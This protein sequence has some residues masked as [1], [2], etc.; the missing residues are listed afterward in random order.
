M[1]SKDQAQALVTSR[2]ENDTVILEERTIEKDWGWV[3]FHQSRR[4]LETK[5]PRYQRFG[6]YAFLVNR[7]DGSVHC[8]DSWFPIESYIQRYEHQL[9]G[10]APSFDADLSLWLE[11]VRFDTTRYVYK[12]ETMDR[13]PEDRCRLWH[14]PAGDTI[15]LIF[16][17][18]PPM[19][20]AFASN[21]DIEEFYRNLFLGGRVLACD[22]I[23]LDGIGCVRLSWSSHTRRARATSGGSQFLSLTSVWSSGLAVKSMTRAI[24]ER[25]CGP[26]PSASFQATGPPTMSHGRRSCPAMPYPDFNM[27]WLASICH[28][29]LM[30]RL[31]IKNVLSCRAMRPNP[32]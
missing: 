18:M 2:L 11:Q 22:V 16:T 15:K 24:S 29:E 26:L 12:G 28:S 14:T 8:A 19:L 27:S 5:D 31:R 3:F 10:D 17:A 20:P 6:A 21:R 32:Y 9:T 25:W 1:L 4:F 7:F 23:R 30:T 13:S